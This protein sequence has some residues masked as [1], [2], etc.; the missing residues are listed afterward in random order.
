M[1]DQQVRTWRQ[2]ALDW[3]RSLVIGTLFTADDVIDAVGVA[4]PD[5]EPNA[6]ASSTGSIFTNAAQ[7]GMIEKAGLPSVNSRQPHRRG[8]RQE[9]WRR[10]DKYGN[11]PTTE[12]SLTLVNTLNPPVDDEP[13]TPKTK[14]MKRRH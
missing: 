13:A 9:I 2:R 5:H 14:V 7:M 11:T 8:G 4:D 6:K 1:T 10:C 3:I 12:P